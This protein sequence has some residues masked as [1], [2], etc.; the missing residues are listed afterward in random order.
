MLHIECILL[1]E[2]LTAVPVCCSFYR[3]PVSLCLTL[4]SGCLGLDP[5]QVTFS[6]RTSVSSSEKWGSDAVYPIRSSGSLYAIIM[7][8]KRGISN[9]VV[10]IGNTGWAVWGL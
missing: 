3:R 4:D 8:V 6:L 2:T 9:P 1:Y 10:Y 5:G 7:H